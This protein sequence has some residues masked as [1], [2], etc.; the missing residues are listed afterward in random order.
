MSQRHWVVSP[1]GGVPGPSAAM[2][3]QPPEALAEPVYMNRLLIEDELAVAETTKMFHSLF[4]LK[5]GGSHRPITASAAS[6]PALVS[7]LTASGARG[8]RKVVFWPKGI[9][10]PATTI[11]PELAAAG[12]A[13]AGAGFAGGGAADGE[14]SGTDAAPKA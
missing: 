3:I 6:L 7:S 12:A 11:G 9:S 4:G 10:V 14:N 8:T 1:L 2:T 5:S 13:A